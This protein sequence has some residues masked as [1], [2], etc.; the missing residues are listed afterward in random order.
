VSKTAIDA[1]DYAQITSLAK[2]FVA[3]LQAARH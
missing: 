3:A 1:G 2:Q